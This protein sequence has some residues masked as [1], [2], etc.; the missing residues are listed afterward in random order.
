[1][2]IA[3]ANLKGG[4]GKTTSAVYLAHAMAGDGSTL[5]IDSDPQ[6]SAL[7][8]SETAGD[9]PFP[10]IA[11]PV[12]NIHR[13]ID[14][15]AGRYTHTV[16]DTPP[17][18]TGIVAS[19]LR[20]VGLVLVTVTPTI[21]DLDRLNATLFLIDEAR[22][23]NDGLDARVLLTRVRQATRSQREVRATLVEDKIPVLATE[24]PLRESIAL[25]GGTVIGDLAEYRQLLEE[26]TGKAE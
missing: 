4:T 7:S 10:V 15:L 8:W 20:S 25:A 3:V 14:A 26:L 13:Q 16:I 21:L 11:L 6:G 9:L 22:A 17:G 19:A 23:L 18:H 24:I 12:T 1:M 5:L 2:R